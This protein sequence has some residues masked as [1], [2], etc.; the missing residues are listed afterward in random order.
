VNFFLATILLFGVTF[1]QELIVYFPDKAYVDIIPDDSKTGVITTHN[2]FE[3]DKLSKQN[4]SYAVLAPPLAFVDTLA[5]YCVY[6]AAWSNGFVFISNDE[7][8]SSRIVS[9]MWS[10]PKMQVD[11]LNF[12]FDNAIPIQLYGRKFPLVGISKLKDL[13]HIMNTDIVNHAI[14]QLDELYG[15]NKSLVSRW[16]P[17]M[18]V[19]GKSHVLAY[20]LFIPIE[21][22]E[23]TN[24]YVPIFTYDWGMIHLIPGKLEALK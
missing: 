7:S 1:S 21:A 11:W 16:T 8:S 3:L 13:S 24:D 14:V 12:I 9:L 15:D 2:I 22:C 10:H 20:A 4:T 6:D 23:N 17:T 18:V 5:R 19:P